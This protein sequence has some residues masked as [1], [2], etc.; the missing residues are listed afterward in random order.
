MC[1]KCLNYKTVLIF[2]SWNQFPK[3]F[4]RPIINVKSIIAIVHSTVVWKK[5]EIHSHKIIFREINSSVAF[6]KFYQKIKRHIVKLVNSRMKIRMPTGIN[7]FTKFLQRKFNPFTSDSR[8]VVYIS[9]KPIC[10][11]KLKFH[12]QFSL[13][14]V[15]IPNS[16]AYFY[17]L[18]LWGIRLV[19]WQSSEKTGSESWTGNLHD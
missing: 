10:F 6:T 5:R 9:V 18:I 19:H 3:L 11:S 17:D 15:N 1:I 2:F 16:K 13:K 14:L 7:V 4:L 12:Y 8:L